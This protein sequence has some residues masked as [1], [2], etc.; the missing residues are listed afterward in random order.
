VTSTI[1]DA[2]LRGGYFDFDAEGCCDRAERLWREA[3]SPAEH[4]RGSAD[5]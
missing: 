3:G 2:E 5:T 4:E 1:R